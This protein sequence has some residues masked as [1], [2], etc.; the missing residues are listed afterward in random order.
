MK[1]FKT[2]HYSFEDRLNVDDFIHPK[3]RTHYDFLCLSLLIFS[4]HCHEASPQAYE[5]TAVLHRVDSR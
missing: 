3:G 4:R 5:A 2:R 1:I